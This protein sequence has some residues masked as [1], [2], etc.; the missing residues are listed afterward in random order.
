MLLL[1]A[2]SEPPNKLATIKQSGELTVLTRI[3]P[4]TYEIDESG[5]MGFE[6]DLVQLFAERLGVRAH[7][8][9]PNKFHEILELVADDKADFAAAGLSVTK[10]RLETLK[11]TPA[12]AQ[13]TQQLVTHTRTHRPK[14]IATVDTLFFE[15]LSSSSHAENL[16]ALKLLHPR[17]VWNET[18]EHTPSE[19]IELVND[20]VLDHTVADSNQFQIVRSKY[21][22]LY[23]ALNLSKPEQIGWAFPIS[24]DH[25]L[26]DEAV[27]FLAEAEKDG[28]LKQLHDKYFDFAK[29]LNYVGICTFWRHIR[30]R[31]PPALTDF[32]NAGEKYS[33]DWRLI[34]AVA[35]QESHWRNNA[36]S[37]TG[38]KGMM[39]LTKVTAK[40]M[41][42]SDRQ[43][44]SQSI[45]GGAHY[46]STRFA[47]MPEHIPEPDKTWMALAAY[48][49]GLGHVEDARII[50]QK[51]GGD[52]NK[53]VDV[54]E[55]L[56]LLT[57][58]KW[59]SKTKHG[60]ARGYEP[61]KYVKNIRHYYNMLNELEKPAKNKQTNKTADEALNIDLPA[62]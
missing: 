46:L 33:I 30:D 55:R 50:T 18:N 28:T 37:P 5:S 31:L 38:V 10:E 22:K 39:M 12:Y 19:L 43:D 13:V 7:F 34:A 9:V 52:P 16:Q 47:V 35:Y 29:A 42:I 53:W 58:K 21:P 27:K 62:L 40:E 57:K 32:K 61:V 45:E 59:Y 20:G 3:D 51:Q 2:C 60:Y 23:A 1:S 8:L 41:G 26:Y 17:L 24:H 6:Y 15:V 36:V 48:N 11:F 25:S 56:P 44:Q 54:K 14:N 49:V 4:T